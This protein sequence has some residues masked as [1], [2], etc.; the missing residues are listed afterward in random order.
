[1]TTA[2]TH[3]RP[4]RRECDKGLGQKWRDVVEGA[5]SLLIMPE[6]AMCDA[7]HRMGQAGGKSLR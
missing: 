2:R 7:K 5:V 3:G 6:S 1:M 4:Y